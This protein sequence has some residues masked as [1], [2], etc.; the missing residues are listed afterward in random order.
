[1]IS[2]R[3]QPYISNRQKI[4]LVALMSGE[5]KVNV[6][7]LMTLLE[8]RIEK[9]PM[10][11]K[12]DMDEPLV[13]HLHYF[14]GEKHWYILEKNAHGVMADCFGYRV[15]PDMKVY[16]FCYVSITELVR[17]GVKIDLDFTL[18]RVSELIEKYSPV[19]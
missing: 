6:E 3:I 9:M 16:E 8:H 14:Q 17:N 1:M 5:G 12:K 2:K 4:E 15:D 19:N 7:Q 18:C 13:A 10:M 11:Y